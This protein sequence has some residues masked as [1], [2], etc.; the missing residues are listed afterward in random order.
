MRWGDQDHTKMSF[1]GTHKRIV[2][3]REIGECLRSAGYKLQDNIELDLMDLFEL[4]QDMIK[5]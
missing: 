2:R 3:K 4:S 1:R 5:W